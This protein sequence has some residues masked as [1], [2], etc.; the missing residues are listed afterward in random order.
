[1]IGDKILRSPIELNL[2]YC[3]KTEN[4]TTNDVGEN[5]LVPDSF[6]SSC[7]RSK[8]SINLFGIFGSIVGSLDNGLFCFQ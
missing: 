3:T 7:R 5:L 4:I 6:G 2:Q 1:M 8:Y